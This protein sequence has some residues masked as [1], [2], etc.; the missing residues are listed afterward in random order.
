MRPDKKRISILGST[1]SIGRS[2]L[3][4]VRSLGG[5]VVVVGVSANTEA[6]ELSRQIAEFKPLVA[7][8]TGVVAG[9]NESPGNQ[10]ALTG[11]AAVDAVALREVEEACRATGTRLLLGPDGL[12]EIASLAEADLVVNALVGAVGIEPTLVAIRAGKRVA[13]ANKESVVAAGSIIMEEARRAGA[14][15]LPI[16]SEHSAIYQCLRGADGR[17]ISRVILTASGGP[18][19]GLDPD[20]L[21]RVTA[22]EALAHPTWRMGRKVTIDSATLLNKGFEVIEAHWLF[23]VAADRIE[24]VVERKSIVHSL[25]EFIDGSVSALLSPPDMRLPIQFAL[26]FPERRET[27]FPKLDLGA[28]GALRFEKPD[29]ERFPCLGLAYDALRRGG[30]A[31]AVLGAAD[32]VAVEAFLADSIRYGDIYSILSKIL[33][34]HRPARADS[35]ETVLKADR[36][37]RGEAKRLVDEVSG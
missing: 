25:V 5:D 30:T 31:P 1:G 3:E 23:G 33:S 4:V 21:A 32:E 20:V 8:V 15:L 26:T 6:R 7:A 34:A 37:A 24:V 18:L 10:G 29:L 14:D 11:R 19:V 13:L 2:T 22:R 17:G 27:A 36:W 9:E 12:V 35:L 28:I 16:D